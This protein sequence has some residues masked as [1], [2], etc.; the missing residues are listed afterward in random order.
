M[1]PFRTILVASAF[2][3]LA[4][5]AVAAS[6][7]SDAAQVRSSDISSAQRQRHHRRYVAPQPAPV[8]SHYRGVADPSFAPNGKPYVVPEYLRNQCYIDEGYG[9][10]SSCSI[11]N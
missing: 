6:L 11:R 10:F 8:F 4:V 2:L 3:A 9:R 7:K 1:D 5:P